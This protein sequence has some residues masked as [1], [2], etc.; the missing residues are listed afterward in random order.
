M[1]RGSWP[2]PAAQ[3]QSPAPLLCSCTPPL[4]LTQTH[5]KLSLGEIPSLWNYPAQRP[6]RILKA[7]RSGQ[8]GSQAP[9]RPSGQPRPPPGR[10]PTGPRRGVGEGRG[11][12]GRRGAGGNQQLGSQ[13]EP[14]V[15]RPGAGTPRPEG[16]TCGGGA[17]GRRQGGWLSRVEARR[18]PIPAACSRR[19]LQR[20]SP[21]PPPSSRLYLPRRARAAR[22]Q[23][24]RGLLMFLDCPAQ[25]ANI[26]RARYPRSR[27]GERKPRHPPGRGDC[28]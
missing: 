23:E 16:C 7:R 15:P 4:T 3:A 1:K 27:A 9:R 10:V 13:S 6:R 18:T 2:S 8:V 26:L 22:E 21:Q 17:G 14:R 28:C 19:G 24:Y 5:S 11:E 20:G 25:P 12:R